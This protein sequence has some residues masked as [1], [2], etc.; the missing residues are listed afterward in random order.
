MPKKDIGPYKWQR[1]RQLGNKQPRPAQPNISQPNQ[2]PKPIG[3]GKDTR[4]Y[5]NEV[6]QDYLKGRGRK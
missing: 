1:N 3:W 6:F 2:K 4:I 5:W